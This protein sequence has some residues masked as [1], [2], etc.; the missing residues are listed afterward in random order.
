MHASTRLLLVLVAIGAIAAGWWILLAINSAPVAIV[1]GGVW[2]VAILIA[3][4]VLFVVGF[5]YNRLTSGRDRKPN[6]ADPATA[7][8]EL[9]DLRDRGLIS[10]DEYEA[11]RAK[12]VDRL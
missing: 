9:A 1:Y 6:P 11:K 8:A 4:R 7:L 2:T 3:T 5:G 10:A 12:I